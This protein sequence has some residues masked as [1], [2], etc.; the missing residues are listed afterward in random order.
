MPPIST[1][2]TTES[3]AR[4][5]YQ[6][7]LAH[8]E[9]HYR[10]LFDSI[11]QGLCTL[12]VLFDADGRPCDYR[13][14]QTNA[15]FERQTGLVNAVGQRM[16]AGDDRVRRQFRD[17]LEREIAREIQIV[18]QR[19]VDLG[20]PKRAEDLGLVQFLLAHPNVGLSRRRDI[21]RKPLRTV[22]RRRPGASPFPAAP[23]S[24]RSRACL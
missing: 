23:C 24:C 5:A 17:R 9:Q 21:L 4:Q 19:H 11:D 1:I 8:S 16:R 7:A 15:A 14:L 13:F 12:E 22:G 2:E 3:A 18:G 20:A 10:M 6:A